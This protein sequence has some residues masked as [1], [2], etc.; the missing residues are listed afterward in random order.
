[1]INSF[2]L[3]AMHDNPAH[4]EA[5]NRVGPLLDGHPTLGFYDVIIG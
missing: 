1:M 5:G 3:M 2:F 4:A